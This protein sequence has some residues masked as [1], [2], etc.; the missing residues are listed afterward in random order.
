MLNIL[1][2]KRIKK[3]LK[4]LS[5]SLI[6]VLVAH[7]SLK[8]GKERYR[9]KIGKLEKEIDELKAEIKA[10]DKQREYRKLKGI[11]ND[12]ERSKFQS[13][14]IYRFFIRL[15]KAISSKIQ[16]NNIEI[17]SD[18]KDSMINKFKIE[19]IGHEPQNVRAFLRRLR[20]MK[21]DFKVVC[22]VE[23]IW[24]DK[25]G[26]SAF[27]IKG[28]ILIIPKEGKKKENKFDPSQTT[29]PHMQ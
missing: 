28:E 6:L 18:E 13:E 26:L 27:I 23:K 2:D 14:A 16:I 9:E 3:F 1:R 29:R 15:S 17:I 4:L 24:T 7:I 20:K 12:W 10:E 8:I 25:K 5:V 21:G 19:G 11:L 22:D